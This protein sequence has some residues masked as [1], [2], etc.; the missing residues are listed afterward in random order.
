MKI[1]YKNNNNKLKI[2]ER[3][4]SKFDKLIMHCVFIGTYQQVLVIINK[5]LCIIHKICVLYYNILY[6]KYVCI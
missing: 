2:Y 3:L 1:L 4:Y 5:I 6:I